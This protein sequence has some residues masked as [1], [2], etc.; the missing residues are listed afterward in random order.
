[1]IQPVIALPPKELGE[2]LRRCRE[3]AGL[4]QATAAD[5]IGV[6]RTTLV[7]IEQGQRPAR[8]D[9]LQ[10]LAAAY[11]TSLNGLLRREAVHL[12]L[13]PR[14]R[15]LPSSDDAGVKEATTLLN[16][17]VRAELELEDALGVKRA[18]SYP[19]ERPLLPGMV[20]E[21][22]TQAEQDAQELRSWLGIGPGPLV[23]VASLL[24]LHLGVRLYFSHLRGSIAGLFAFDDRAGACMLLNSAHPRERLTQ[25]A[26]H[27]VGHLIATR[28]EPSVLA[29]D[30]SEDS[31]AEKYAAAFARAFLTPAR[32]VRQRFADLTAGQS[33]LSRRHV[34]LLAHAFGVSREAMV[35]RLEELSLAKRGTWDWFI[36][37]GGISKDHEQQV[38]GHS[39]DQSGH[40]ARGAGNGAVR[41]ALLVREAWARGLYSEGQ[42]AALFSVDRQRMRELLDGSEELGEGADEILRLG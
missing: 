11:K 18:P 24:E 4:T 22:T 32:L 37:N 20:G 35:R 21:L 16:T 9:E 40:P 29:L 39:M 41:L 34:I 13:V 15:K 8:L 6:A 17:F 5:A 12:D 14:F 1:M 3:I 28:R 30:T 27:E 33:Y 31:R 19:P 26:M 38:L 23:D 7:A 42:L 10:G 36:S 2:R 25:T